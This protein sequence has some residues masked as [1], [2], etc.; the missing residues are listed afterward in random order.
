MLHHTRG[1]VLHTIPYSDSSLIAKIYTEQFGLQSYIVSGARSKRGKAK[2]NLL[3]PLMQVELVVQHKAKSRL[4]RIMEIGCKAPY[5]HIHEDIVKTSIALFL[6]EVLYKAIREEEKNPGLFEFLSHSLQI[7]DLETGSCHNFH[8][9]FLLQLSRYLGFFPHSAESPAHKI[10]DL[11]EGVF[12]ATEP[13]HPYFL[14]P[15]LGEK[16][17]RL[18]QTN[19]ENMQEFTIGNL[20]RRRLLERLLWYYE[21]HL[22]NMR[23][24]KSHKV[25]EEVMG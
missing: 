2:G 25:L 13:H 1:I 10:F 16:L 12:R 5:R 21:M 20:D 6:A 9:C 24:V 3:Q 8:L 4:Q 7:L 14:E 19:Y 11:Q 17:L 18:M 15:E 23:D 22:E